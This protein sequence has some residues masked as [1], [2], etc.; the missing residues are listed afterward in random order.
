MDDVR[1][2]S[3]LRAIRKKGLRQADVAAAA[4]VSQQ[5]VS[6]LERGIF[7][8]LAAVRRICRALGASVSLSLDWRGG[9]FDRLTDAGHAR[10]VELTAAFLRSCGW[11]V[12]VEFS[13]NHYGDRGSVDILAWHPVFQTLLV[14]EVK[15]SIRNVGEL[16]RRLDIKLR[17]VPRQAAEANGWKV[18]HVAAILVV[19][20]SSAMWRA[21]RVHE[22]SFAAA[23]PARTAELKRWLR[24]PD[25][26]IKGVLFVRDTVRG[27]T[28]RRSFSGNGSG[29]RSGLVSGPESGSK[30]G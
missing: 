14:I 9:A 29:T 6:D 21:V 8:S 7:D 1:V 18:R 27:G 26:P 20:G 3:I 15:T 10:L 22:A 11:L 4:E 30:Q 23:L 2:G 24:R 25:R 13:F 28:G 19:P 12:I 5:S 16:F 17:V